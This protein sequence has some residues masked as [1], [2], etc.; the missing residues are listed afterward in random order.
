MAHFHLSISDILL[1][2]LLL[3][4]YELLGLDMVRDVIKVNGNRIYFMKLNGIHSNLNKFIIFVVAVA[5]L[6]F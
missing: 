1:H 4:L 2:M 3:L 5:L 6:R